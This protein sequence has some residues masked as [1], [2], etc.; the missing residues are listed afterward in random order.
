MS[1]AGD[2]NV[3]GYVPYTKMPSQQLAIMLHKSQLRVN[4]LV[5][6]NQELQ[7]QVNDLEYKAS[8]Y[9]TTAT[10]FDTLI[11]AINENPMAKKAWDNMMMCLRLCENE[12]DR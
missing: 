9:Y 2:D 12:E 4:A 3:S 10:H 1:D 6:K 7:K 5:S 11:K 8:Q